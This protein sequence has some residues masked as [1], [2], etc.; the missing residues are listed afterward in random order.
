MTAQHGWL[1]IIMEGDYHIILQMDTKL[2]HG[3]L[4]SKVVDNWKMDHNLDLLRG[5]L[6]DHSEV[7]I[8]YVNRKANK[9]EDL[10]VN[11]GVSQRQEFQ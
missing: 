7:Q 9:P 11:Y 4:V 3:K 8:H 5:L 2:V 1:P 10:L 6:W